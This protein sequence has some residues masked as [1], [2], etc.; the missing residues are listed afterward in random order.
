MLEGIMSVPKGITMIWGETTFLSGNVTVSRTFRTGTFSAIWIWIMSSSMS[1]IQTAA[2]LW[3]AKQELSTLAD[4]TCQCRVHFPKYIKLPVFFRIKVT[5]CLCRDWVPK[6]T[7]K[8]SY[9][10]GIFGCLT[11]LSAPRHPQEASAVARIRDEPQ[12]CRKNKFNR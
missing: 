10:H 5:W 2:P 9:Q 11:G 7:R 12:K 1:F 6:G 3:Q 8:V 4:L